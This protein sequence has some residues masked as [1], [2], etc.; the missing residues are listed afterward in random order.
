VIQKNFGILQTAIILRSHSLFHTL[1]N[2]VQCFRIKCTI[3]HEL[4]PS[5]IAPRITMGTGRQ[6]SFFQH[7]DSKITVAL[8]TIQCPLTRNRNY[9]TLY[10]LTGKFELIRM[11]TAKVSNS[12]YFTSKIFHEVNIKFHNSISSKQFR[13]IFGFL[14]LA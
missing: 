4:R 9:E 5:L 6:T 14:H 11:S 10:V 8:K 1:Q 3:T 7:I 2:L 13:D 12:Q